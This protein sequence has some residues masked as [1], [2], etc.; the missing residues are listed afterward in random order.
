[1]LIHL[2]CKLFVYSRLRRVVVIRKEE[3]W[4][5]YLIDRSGN[6]RCFPF[7]GTTEWQPSAFIKTD[8]NPAGRVQ[9]FAETKSIQ[10]K[11]NKITSPS[12]L[13]F[14]KKYSRKKDYVKCLTKTVAIHLN[15]IK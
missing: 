1:M 9:L 3:Y 8:I 6:E 14:T 4:E 10:R 5:S 11:A 12:S 2:C 7:D 15:S 13:S